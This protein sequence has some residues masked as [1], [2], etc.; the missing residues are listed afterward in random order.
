MV[1]KYRVNTEGVLHFV[2]APPQYFNK[3]LRGFKT[4]V[5][6]AIN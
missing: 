2:E 6:L 5:R 4:L 1:D 3:T